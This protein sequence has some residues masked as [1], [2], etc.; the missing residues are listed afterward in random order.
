MQY[1]GELLALAAAFFFGGSV[2]YMRLGMLRGTRDMAMFVTLLVN[3]IINLTMITAWWIFGL[4]PPINLLGLA[5]FALAGF[6]TSNLGRLF[7]AISM[8]S[9]GASRASAFKIGAPIFTITIGIFVLGEQVSFLALG[10]MA[11]VIIGL[12]VITGSMQE[13]LEGRGTSSQHND[14]VHNSKAVSP[15]AEASA[16]DSQTE[17]GYKSMV[18]K[19]VIFGVLSGLAFALGQVFRK[20]GVDAI[21]SSVVGVSVGS[22]VAIT[23][24]WLAMVQ[25]IG[26]KGF[27]E[28]VAV[29]FNKSFVVSGV[30]SSLALYSFFLSLQFTTVSK[31]NVLVNTEVWTTMLIGYFVLGKA[32][33]LNRQLFLGVVAVFIG[34]VLTI[35]Y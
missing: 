25:R 5:Y 6:L 18:K 13:K 22:L 26:F 3:N 27:K 20:V 12:L 30:F 24:Y 2:V 16:K 32:E 11:I 19:G 8:E 10:G 17:Q 35:L 15:L 21:P 9:I 23:C 29:S 1:L 33:N 34:V 4:I 28:Q 14:A 31:A 7:Q